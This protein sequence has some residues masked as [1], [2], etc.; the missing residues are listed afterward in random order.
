M[1]LQADIEDLEYLK[2]RR[3]CLLKEDR[4]PRRLTPYAVGPSDK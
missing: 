1:G 2:D 3:D 4:L